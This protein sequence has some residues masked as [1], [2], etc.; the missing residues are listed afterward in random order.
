MI[1]SAKHLVFMV[2]RSLFKGQ[3]IEAAI[4]FLVALA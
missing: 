1:I 2:Y 3:E 4:E